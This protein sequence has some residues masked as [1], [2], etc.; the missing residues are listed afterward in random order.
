MSFTRS[1]GNIPWRSFSQISVF[2]PLKKMLEEV[3]SFGSSQDIS[4]ED[5]DGFGPVS[6]TRKTDFT[7]LFE[8]R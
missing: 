2:L 4:Y 1:F 6:T 3:Y 7:A 5:K 8:D